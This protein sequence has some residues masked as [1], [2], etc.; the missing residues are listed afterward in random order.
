MSPSENNNSSNDTS[1]GYKPAMSTKV[2]T[3]TVRGGANTQKTPRDIKKVSK[4]SNPT[5]EPHFD[6][7]LAETV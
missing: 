7:S 3:H 5:L 4:Q 6:P 1:A 2:T